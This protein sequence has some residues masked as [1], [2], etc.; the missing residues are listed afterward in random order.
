MKSC[1]FIGHKNTSQNIKPLLETVLKHLITKENVTSFYVGTHGNFDAIA[2]ELLINLKVQYPHINYTIVLS[3]MNQKINDNTNYSNTI[4][5]DG[6]ENVP[7]KFA[8]IESNKWMIQK[9]D[10]LVCYITNTFTNAIKFKEFAIKK[11][12]TIIE[13]R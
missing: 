10:F 5:P 4:Y 13:I 7:L 11:K 9:C 1:T 6:L 3:Y 12:K 2:K 8:I